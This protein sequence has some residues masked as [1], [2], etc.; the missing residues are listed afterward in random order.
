MHRL[1]Q[2][3]L[4]AIPGVG[5]SIGNRQ[6]QLLFYLQALEKMPVD[7]WDALSPELRTWY[8]MTA[9]LYNRRGSGIILPDFK[10]AEPEEEPKGATVL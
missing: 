2:E 7:K 3:L 1:E 8:N 4:C 9:S 5:R 6:K 10:D